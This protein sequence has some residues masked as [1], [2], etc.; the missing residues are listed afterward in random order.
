MLFFLFHI[1]HGISSLIHGFT[2]L[3]TTTVNGYCLPLHDKWPLLVMHL[4]LHVASC[5]AVSLLTILYVLRLVYSWGNKLL[6]L[7]AYPNPS[8]QLLLILP[9]QNNKSDKA[10]FTHDVW[11][12][13]VF[14]VGS[15]AVFS[16]WPHPSYC[17]SIIHH[18][19]W[20]SNIYLLVCAMAWAINRFNC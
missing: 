13:T 17:I 15:R 8:L 16:T 2:K 19:Q 10:P 18:L 14:G 5:S 6:L 1:L 7:F 9:M 11:K 20:C 4:L 12:S 3:Y